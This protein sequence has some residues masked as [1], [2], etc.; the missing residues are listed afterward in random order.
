MF[1]LKA[2]PY[3]PFGVKGAPKG[4]RYAGKLTKELIYKKL[5]PP[6]IH[7]LESKNPPDEKW[8]RKYKHHQWLT[9]NIGNPHL[10]KQV[11]VVT[12]LMRIS[13]NWSTFKRNF[14]RAFPSGP[15]QSEMPFLE[16]QDD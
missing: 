15:E 4:P 9:N 5:P 14:S 1:R 7:E 13:P 6:V 2:W 8:Q 16:E 12:T 11:A 10:E 3:P